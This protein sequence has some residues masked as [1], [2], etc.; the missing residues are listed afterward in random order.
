MAGKINIVSLLLLGLSATAWAVAGRSVA[1]PLIWL[2]VLV[3][4]SLALQP[5]EIP[6]FVHRLLKTAAVLIGVSLLQVLFRRSGTPLVSIQ[7]VVLVF[8]DGFREAVLLW[9]R[10]MILFVLARVMASAPIFQFMILTSRMRISLNFSLLLLLT[11]NLIPFIF[12]EARRVLWSFRFRG[13]SLRHL[14]FNDK[15]IAVKQLA[16]AILMR[17]VGY[18]FHSALTLELRGYGQS[19]FGSIPARIPFHR[20]DLALILLTAAVNTAGLILF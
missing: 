7:G 5:E 11:V 9:I 6:F 16:F 13:L 18:V 10:F 3:L 15:G 12:T 8:S 2:A 17:S 14:S 19:R 20:A 1:M 4:F